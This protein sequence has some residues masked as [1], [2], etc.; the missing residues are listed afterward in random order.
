MRPLSVRVKQLYKEL[1]WLGSAAPQGYETMRDRIKS[2]FLKN[3][4]LTDPIEIKVAIGRGNYAKKE[5]EAL[6]NF[7]RYESF[8]KMY[9]VLV[10]F[11]AMKK[12]Y[13]PL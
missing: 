13:D 2:E 10:R 12:R 4:N 7:H 5:L 11:R 3:K 8:V 1:L 9:R 6:I